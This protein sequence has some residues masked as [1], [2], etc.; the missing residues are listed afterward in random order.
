MA[1]IAVSEFVN[2]YMYDFSSH[3][4]GKDLYRAKSRE[5]DIRIT[6]E[7]N[8][9]EFQI[10]I[11]AYGVGSLQLP[12]DKHS[13]MF[14]RLERENSE[15]TDRSVIESIFS[16]PAFSRFDQ[17]NVLPLIYDEKERHCN[18]MLF[19]YEKAKREAA[20]VTRVTAGRGR[21]HPVYRFFDA[22]G[23]YICEVRYGGASANALQRGLWTNTKT[24]VQYFESIINGWI[25]YSHNL[26]LF[27]L[28][29]HALVASESGHSEALEQ[30]KRTLTK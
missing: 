15:V 4:V 7:I 18:I 24:G 14:P 27:Q 17:V 26:I 8:K 10:S 25:D 28:F 22:Q 11:K 13:L 20:R 23:E 12:T 16:D 19:D 6:D 1:E 2:Q 5:E 30:V 9:Q 29:S 3:H 21:K